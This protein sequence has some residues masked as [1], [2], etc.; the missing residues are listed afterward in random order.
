[1]RYRLAALMLFAL[2]L[3]AMLPL[4]SVLAAPAP[5]PYAILDIG[6]PP[7]GETAEQYRQR[8][9][10]AQTHPLSTC[11]MSSP[12]VRRL[13]SVARMENAR[14]WLTKNI[15]ITAEGEERRIRFTFRAG[16]R[17][18][19]VTIINAFLRESLRGGEEG[20]KW[21]EE[22][23][24]IHE[25]CILDLEKRI[26]TSRDRQEAASY[27]EGINYLRSVRIPA[28]RA[29]IARLKQRIVIQWAR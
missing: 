19:S 8:V 25:K 23:V 17:D 6:P 10:A 3:F 16:T 9:I 2:V 15:R 28:C 7:K 5:E 4:M 26:K 29:E 1:M 24:H 13:P 14:P 22:C 11:G 21:G 20:I 18:E 12:E 27:R